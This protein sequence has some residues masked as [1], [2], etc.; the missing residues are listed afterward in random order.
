MRGL[1]VAGCASV[2]VG[3]AHAM[4]PR[5]PRPRAPFGALGPTPVMEFKELSS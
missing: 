5:T 2:G 4:E 3:R 1:Q